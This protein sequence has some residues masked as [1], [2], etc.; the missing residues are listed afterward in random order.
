MSNGLIEMGKS[1]LQMTPNRTC[2]GPMAEACLVCGRKVCEEVVWLDEV[3]RGK[4][5]RMGP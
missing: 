1:E 5:H 4:C 3:G 2:K